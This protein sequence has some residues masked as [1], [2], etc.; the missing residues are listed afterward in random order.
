MLSLIRKFT[1]RLARKGIELRTKKDLTV[2]ARLSPDI[3]FIVCVSA[4]NQSISQGHIRS[5]S[6]NRRIPVNARG[7]ITWVNST[8]NTSSFNV[9]VKKGRS[10]ANAIS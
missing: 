2:N 4:K 7:Q 8:P 6:L 5:S 9:Q 1:R 3:G 10:T